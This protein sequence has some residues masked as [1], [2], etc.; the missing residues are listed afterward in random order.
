MDQET[1]MT[2]EIHNPEIERIVNEA[3]LSGRYGTAQD[4]V[5]EAVFAWRGQ[6]SAAGVP[7]TSPKKTLLEFFRES[8][9][10]GLELEFERDKSIDRDVTL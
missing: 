7:R 8:P 4:V 1:G 3:V 2:I 10:V 6:Q 9:L 5:S